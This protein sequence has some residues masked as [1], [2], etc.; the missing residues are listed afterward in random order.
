MTDLTK[1]LRVGE[2]KHQRFKRVS[3]NISLRLSTRKK[4]RG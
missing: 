1:S 4:K 3:L 2:E